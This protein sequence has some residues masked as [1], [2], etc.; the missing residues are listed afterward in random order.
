MFS[1]KGFKFLS[2]FLLLSFSI[3]INAQNHLPYW[4]SDGSKALEYSKEHEVPL[5][6]VFAGSDWCVPCIKF[7]KTILRD[8][9][10][11]N[12]AFHNVAL[13][14]LDFPIK[15]KNKLLKEQQVHNDKWAERYNKRGSF[16]HV[17]LLSDKE[18][19][20]AD[21]KFH[22]QSPQQFINELEAAQ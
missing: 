1:F 19:K 22:N 16:P 20:I 21:L 12:Y 18:E 7:K 11:D 10:F 8:S 6:V 5:L 15:K 2:V 17:V 14:Y 3:Q 4:F 13:L 9:L